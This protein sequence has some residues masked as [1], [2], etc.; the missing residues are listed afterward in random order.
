[1]KTVNVTLLFGAVCLGVLCTLIFQDTYFDQPSMTLPSNVEDHSVGFSYLDAI[2]VMLTAATVVLTGVAVVIALI[3]W[4]TFK[5]IQENA[6][7]AIRTEVA[8][9]M[10][11]L[12]GTIKDEVQQITFQT[13]SSSVSFEDWEEEEIDGNS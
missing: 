13:S 8:K 2:G 3:S 10:S 4:F 9:E 7:R 11:K 12:R 6:R 1:M 5:G